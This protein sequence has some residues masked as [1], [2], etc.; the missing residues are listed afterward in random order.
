LESSVEVSD[1][2]TPSSF[3]MPMTSLSSPD[4][5]ED[6]A[7]EHTVSLSLLPTYPIQL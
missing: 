3:H 1:A 7:D 6:A 2:R 4:D 5:D